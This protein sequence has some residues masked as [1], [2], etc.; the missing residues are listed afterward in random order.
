MSITLMPPVPI[1]FSS[2]NAAG[3]KLTDV[4][5]LLLISQI[6]RLD[7]ESVRPYLVSEKLIHPDTN[8]DIVLGILHQARL[9]LNIATDEEKHASE[10]YL[11]QHCFPVF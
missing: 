10:T 9:K 2:K 7:L 5:Q 1:S 3:E 6:R 11:R 8:N 4:E